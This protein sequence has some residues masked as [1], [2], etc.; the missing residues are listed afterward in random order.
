MLRK[1]LTVVALLGITNYSIAQ[2]Q[3]GTLKGTIT[4]HETGETVPM[5][6]VVLELN[7]A[8][9]AGAVADFDG[10]YTIKPI[11]PGR[12][13]VKVSFIGFATKEISD[14]LVTSNKITFV[15]AA[16]KPESAV[17]GEV[18]LVEYVVPLIDPDKSGTTKT[19]EEI[20]ALPTRNVQSVAAQTAG[21]Y[22]EDEGEDL[23]VRGSRD[24]ATFYYIDG[25][26]VRASNSLPQSSIEQMTVITGG[27]PASY[28]DATGGVISIT[29]RGPS[30]EFFGGVEA[31]TST[32]LDPYGYNLFGFN[33][34]GPLKRN[35]EGNSVLGFFL[36]G[37]YESVKDGD[38][39]AVGAYKV[40]D[41]VMSD[42]E[43]NPLIFSMDNGN[44]Q[45]Q[46]AAEFVSMEDLEYIDARQNVARTNANI[47]GKIDF[48]PTLNTNIT[49]GGN[50]SNSNYRNYDRDYSLFNPSHN[51][52]HI[53]QSWRVYG[54][55]QQSF[56]ASG[57]EQS[58]ST[59]KNA[60]FTLQADYSKDTEIR[61]DANHGDKLFNYGYI[62]KFTPVREF[63]ANT[64]Q[65]W[66]ND[67]NMI[68]IIGLDASGNPSPGDTL[69]NMPTSDGAGGTNFDLTQNL[70]SYYNFE[71]GDL[72]TNASNYTQSYYD[73]IGAESVS[74]LDQIRGIGAM[75]NGDYAEDVHSLWYNTGRASRYY[76]KWNASQFR[77]TGSASADINDHAIQFGF[78]YEQRDDRFYRFYPVGLWTLA[79]QQANNYIGLYDGPYE[80]LFSDENGNFVI[81]NQ[82]SYNYDEMS[83]F[84]KNFRDEYGI[85]YDDYV[86]IHTYNPDQLDVGM[87]SADELLSN[88]S[89]NYA[90]WYGY[91]YQGNMIEGVQPGMN[92]FLTAKDENDNY[93]R[94]V[95]A[96][97]PIYVAGY[98]QDKFAFEDIIFNIGVRVDR[99]D[100]NQE[101]LKDRYSLYNV[102]TAGEVTDFGVHPSNIGDDYVVYVDDNT[103]AASITGYRNGDDW[104]NAEGLPINDPSALNIS[105]GVLPMLVD[106]DALLNGDPLNKGLSADAFKDYEP[107]VTIMPRISFNFPISDEAM[108]YAYYDVLAQRPSRN[109]LDPIDYLLLAYKDQN[110]YINNPDLKSQKTTNYEVG[111]KQRLSSSSAL[112]INA[113]YK[114]MRDMIQYT[115]VAYAFPQEYFTYGNLDF[116][117]VKGLS[118]AYE[119]RRTKNVSFNANYTM[120]FAD[121]SGSSATSGVNI[122][123]SEQPNLRTTLPLDFDQRHNL[124]ASVDF[125]YGSGK[126]YNG[127]LLN[128][129]QILSNMGVNLVATAGSGTPYSRQLNATREAM[130]GIND[131]DYLEGSI[132]GSRLPWTYRMDMRV[133]KSFDLTWGQEENQKSASVNVY[134]QVQNL[135]N[136]ANIVSV[137]QYT[138]NPDDDGYLATA[139]GIGDIQDQADPTSFA[140]LYSLKLNN[141]DNYTRPR[142]VRLGVT[143]DF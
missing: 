1:L 120:Q 61:Q 113:F 13:T 60:F 103:N 54:R 40:K 112:S 127:P 52:Q 25:V 4:E 125:R 67:D 35:E 56:G 22:Q 6:N 68:N 76:Y 83:S 10:K 90:S 96:F 142:T 143:L 97:Q 130:F 101:V 27:L 114:E 45:A 141:P 72:N 64:P 121:G 92:E 20:T 94:E 50:F 89:Y 2:T 80:Y 24:D 84:A 136:T 117:T 43:E 19:K 137:Y 102:M 105:K 118:L 99:Y 57:D 66:E 100:A 87:F 73:F 124:T 53:E 39:S 126:S 65:E 93:K 12:Y 139:V 75:V 122:V 51:L 134:L 111:F 38:P 55:F 129:K 5:A 106:P 135:L 41:D 29:T 7:G 116:G 78:E 28:G 49:F 81:G 107:E 59:L 23:N 63:V 123:S 46:R 95:G 30:N 58:A 14:V 48:K 140:D 33:L 31:I 138:G 8:V 132:N 9:I 32:L 110:T 47:Q 115:R 18:E 34:S 44:V 79:Q 86:D 62:G 37:E 11:D 108:F 17:I 21:I 109:R 15:N 3:S 16:L 104:Y 69:F 74:T 42:L 26:K 71:A 128:G 133:N 88:W 77:F 91:D 82:H 36:S 70:I 98:I 131:R 119:M 85:S